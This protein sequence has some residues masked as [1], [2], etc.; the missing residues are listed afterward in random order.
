MKP[1]SVPAMYLHK[2]TRL[3]NGIHF[4]ISTWDILRFISMT[5]L[6]KKNSVKIMPTKKGT[7]YKNYKSFLHKQN[8]GT[9]V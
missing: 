6:Q 1:S 8:S 5:F 7:I 2:E 3:K 4:C 9:F